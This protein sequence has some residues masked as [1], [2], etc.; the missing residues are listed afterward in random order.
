MSMK[1]MEQWM[2][3]TARDVP[4]DEWD[5]LVRS[6]YEEY[7]ELNRQER[8]ERDHPYEDEEEAENE[9]V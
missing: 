1:S 5:V 7:C 9:D 2:D 4:M 6:D 3:Y 8:Y